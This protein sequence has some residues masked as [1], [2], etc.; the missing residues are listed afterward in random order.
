MKNRVRDILHCDMNNCYASIEV[1][2]NPTL[3]GLPIAVCGS[4]SD[5]GG[6]V[7][8]KSH[9]A[10][11]KGVKTGEVIWQ[12]KNKCPDLV[13]VPP[14]YEEYLRHSIMAKKIYYSYTNQVE[15]FGLDEA[16]LDVSG[17]TKLFGSSENIAKEIRIRMKKE[18]GITVSIGVSFNKVF[19]KLGSD[20]KKPDGI[21][22]IKKDE[23]N[24]KIWPLPVE[25]MIG[26]GRATKN[27]L[28]KLNIFTLGDLAN[29]DPKIIKKILGIN[30]VKL[31]SYANGN[32]ESVVSDINEMAPIKTVGNGTT[33]RKDLV[34]DDEVRDV[35]KLL[36]LKVCKRLIEY[37]LEAKG[38]QISIKDINLNSH[39]FHQV[40]SY[41]TFSSIILAERA[42][43][44]FEKYDWKNHIRA[45]TIRA[46]NLSNIYETQ[47]DYYAIVEGFEKKTNL[48]KTLYELREKY[49]KDI[50]S[51][52]SLKN[53][54]KLPKNLK[55]IYTLPNGN[56]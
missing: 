37:G 47:L 23:F 38:V 5:R 40:Y 41:S 27:K 49:G 46:I 2:L 54:T 29:S 20:M 43:R 8:A 10:K 52:A 56:R 33:L 34:N 55:E 4:Q 22:I 51:F 25:E 48:D 32:D 26:V 36:S 21:T 14:H 6:I 9:E 13:I 53:N 17:S 44:L 19:A 30:G 31:W 15:S 7:L 35:F 11:I 42:M 28:N 50:I 3:K 39:K 24:I 45:V 1:K 16:W 12:A 18:L